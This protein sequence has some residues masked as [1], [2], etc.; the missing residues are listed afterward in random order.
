MMFR[1]IK[2]NALL[3][4]KTE[5]LGVLFFAAVIVL[6][7]VST[8]AQCS[9]T[10]DASGVWEI[11]QGARG[12]VITRLD[13]KQSGGALSGKA[14]REGVGGAKAVTG[15]V[16]GDADGDAFSLAISWPDVSEHTI[17]RAKVAALGKLAGE[18]YI[19]P[20]KR[21]RD[22]WY[23]DQALTC[24][25]ISGKSRGNLTSKLSA[26][27]TVKTGQA[28]G[29]LLNV[30]TMVASQAVFQSPY[31]GQGFAV[32]T[33]DAGP[34]HPNAEVWVKYNGSRDR[35]LFMKQPKGGMQVPVQRGQ[36]YAYVLM[37]SRNVLATAT[38]VGQ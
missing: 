19:G 25:W 13:L 26:D 10:W 18:T 14:S 32:L 24:G 3:C 1:A 28:T 33:W 6:L 2:F 36:V 8:Q 38:V 9:K 5:L 12:G 30:P 37:D 22:T 35:V 11:R 4:R 31:A 20:D 15:D 29:S 23:S 7:P 27:D 16:I 34:G 17:Y 21:N